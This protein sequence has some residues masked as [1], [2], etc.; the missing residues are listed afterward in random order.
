MAAKNG[1]TFCISAYLLWGVLPIYWKQMLHISSFEI[2]ANRFIWS[3][4]FTAFLIFISGQRGIFLAETKIILKSYRKI[5]VLCAASILIVFNWGIFIYAVNDGQITATSMGY[6]INPLVSVL[7]AV[8][9]LKEKLNKRQVCAVLFAICGIIFMVWHFKT[10]PWISLVLAFTFAFYGL[11]KKQLA[12]SAMTSIFYESFLMTP[13][14]AL[15]EYFLSAKGGIY[16]VL[17]LRDLLLLIGCGAVTAIPMLFFT[18]GAK[19]ISLKMLGFMQYIAPTISLLIG[20]FIYKEVFT[21]VHIISF[22]CIW[23]G[24]LL[25]TL[26]QGAEA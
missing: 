15:Y 22:G 8:V 7:L 21:I 1:L 14:A 11:I 10:L 26:S 18:A 12:L 16:S 5:L 17:T 9:F 25:F 4:V 20:I 19:R 3:A 24:V 13:F 23:A 2:L 6:Y